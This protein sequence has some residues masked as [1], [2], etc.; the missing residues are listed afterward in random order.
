MESMN[1][2]ELVKACPFFANLQ[3]SDHQ[4][5]LHYGKL[6]MFAK[7]KTIYTIGKQSMDMFFTILSGEISIMTKDGQVLQ[8][9]KRGAF[10]SDLDVSL[11]LEGRAGII[12]AAK[13]TEIFVWYVG[14]IKKHLPVF[15]KR[16]TGTH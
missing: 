2:L 9:M 1:L 3:E 14:V 11:L 8:Q 10:V 16:F 15:V 5:L 6:N 13:P 7:R 12:Q 4:L